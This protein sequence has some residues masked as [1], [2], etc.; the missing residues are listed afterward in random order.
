M[1]IIAQLFISLLNCA[2][3]VGYC[4]IFY[5]TSEL[6]AKS[7]SDLSGFEVPQVE[8]C[9]LKNKFKKSHPNSNE[10]K[11]SPYIIEKI[12]EPNNYTVTFTQNYLEVLLKSYF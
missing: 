12:T 1:R 8:N 5:F 2:L 9:I 6:C 4:I 10:L 3:S 11:L 7:C